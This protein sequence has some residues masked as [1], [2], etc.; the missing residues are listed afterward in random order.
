[1]TPMLLM[2]HGA[3][4]MASFIIALFFV[5]FWR[6]TRDKFFLLFASAFFVDCLGRVISRAIPH[7]DEQAPDF[8]LLRLLSFLIILWAIAYKNRMVKKTKRPDV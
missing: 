5:R 7:S 2:L 6:T 8:Y 3:G 1:M 4:A